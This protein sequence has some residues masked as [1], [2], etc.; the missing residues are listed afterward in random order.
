V[1]EINGKF[2]IGGS[3]GKI[4]GCLTTNDC[5]VSANWTD[6]AAV[7][8]FSGEILGFARFGNFLILTGNAGKISSCPYKTADCSLGSNWSSAEQTEQTNRWTGIA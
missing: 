3:G 8:N 5:S 1:T 2:I 4:S 6:A 7:S